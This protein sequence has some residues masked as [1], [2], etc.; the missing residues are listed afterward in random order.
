MNKFEKVV[1]YIISLIKEEKLK[2]SDKLPSIRAMAE[3]FS[4]NK[5]TIIRA[6]QELEGKHYIYSVSKSG[7]YVIESMERE[8][9]NLEV[10]DFYRQVLI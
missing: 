1:R 6:Y 4:C 8:E 2:P 3:E 5:S 7:Y 9:D 10:F